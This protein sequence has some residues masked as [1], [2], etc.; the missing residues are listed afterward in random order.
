MKYMSLDDSHVQQALTSIMKGSR[1]T[2]R[3]PLF[4]L[5]F[6]VAIWLISKW[7]LKPPES[8]SVV[9]ICVISR[10]VIKSFDHF[11]KIIL[12]NPELEFPATPSRCAAGYHGK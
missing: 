5:V 12:P 8:Q 11:K 1:Q 9:L 6:F 4:A 7:L 3:L 2:R 10:Q